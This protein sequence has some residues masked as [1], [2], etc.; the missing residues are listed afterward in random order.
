[1]A[2]KKKPTK[3]SARTPLPTRPTSVQEAEN[4][5]M[6]APTM[7]EMLES[8]NRQIEELQRQLSNNSEQPSTSSPIFTERLD[9]SSPPPPPPLPPPPPPAVLTTPPQ[10]APAIQQVV[11]QVLG[12]QQAEINNSEAVANFLTLGATLDTKIKN[13]IWAGQYVELGS[14]SCRTDAS[15]AVNVTESSDGQPHVAL[16][17]RK[18][19]PP[20]NIYDWFRLFATYAAVYAERKPEQAPSLFTYLIRII[21]MQRRHGGFAWRIY[22][23]QFRRIRAFAPNIPWHILNWQV[24]NEALHTDTASPSPSSATAH[25]SDSE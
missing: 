9:K 13:K 14:L 11:E 23:E 5:D 8:A 22:D 7:Q 21:D 2:G 25:D 6:D 4:E 15:L 16:T 20:Q 3:C 10:V 1:M 18:P 19:K 17:T 12:L 24:A